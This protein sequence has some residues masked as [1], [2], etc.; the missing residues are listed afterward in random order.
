MSNIAKIVQYTHHVSQSQYKGFVVED[1]VVNEVLKSRNSYVCSDPI[2]VDTME[3]KEAAEYISGEPFKVEI[4]DRSHNYVIKFSDD[5]D[6][7]RVKEWMKEKGGSYEFDEL[8]CV[9]E[10]ELP[11]EY[12]C[13]CAAMKAWLVQDGWGTKAISERDKYWVFDKSP[14]VEY[15]G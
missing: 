2:P 1:V 9:N 4:M 14:V 11:E 7:E 12:H 8:E 15:S 3:L 10:G 13:W 6:L 5:R